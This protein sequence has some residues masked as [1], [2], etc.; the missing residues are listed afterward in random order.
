MISQKEAK[1]LIFRIKV[2]AHVLCSDKVGK[3][4]LK[5][6]IQ[7]CHYVISNNESIL[8][9]ASKDTRVNLDASEAIR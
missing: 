9:D 4:P 8:F 1:C 5:E 6:L 2:A 3:F 7:Q